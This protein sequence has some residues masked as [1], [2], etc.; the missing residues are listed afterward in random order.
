MTVITTQGRESM[1]AADV[2][3]PGFQ[4]V[5]QAVANS[6]VFVWSHRLTWPLDADT[7][8]SYES[9]IIFSADPEAGVKY[10]LAVPTGTE[11]RLNVPDSDVVDTGEW[12]EILPRNSPHKARG[13]IRVG[14]LAGIV[15][16]EFAQRVPHNSVTMLHRGSWIRLTQVPKD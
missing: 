15:R 12:F 13:I 14:P 6:T 16:V 1:T 11:A 2:I 10:R 8:Y 3:P 9:L 4:D 7:D 5:D